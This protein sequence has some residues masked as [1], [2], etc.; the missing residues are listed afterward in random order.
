MPPLSEIG[1]AVL[2]A[3]KEKE[4]GEETDK[5]REKGGGGGEALTASSFFLPLFS[6]Y[7]LPPFSSSFL[8]VLDWNICPRWR[9]KTGEKEG[10][11][12]E[13]GSA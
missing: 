3:E 4:E 1:V 9:W 8:S 13:G 12:G 7:L 6:L 2:V 5:E 10:K 11:G